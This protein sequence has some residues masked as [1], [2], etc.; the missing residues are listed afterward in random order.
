VRVLCW[1]LGRGLLPGADCVRGTHGCH[2][3]RRCVCKL[4][5]GP[6]LAITLLVV[7]SPAMHDKSTASMAQKDA[8]KLCRCVYASCVLKL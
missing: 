6:R 3:V 4:R 5:L 8:T 7:F 1:L 2:Q